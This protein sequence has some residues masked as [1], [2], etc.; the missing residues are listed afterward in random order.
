MKLFSAKPLTTVRFG[1][2]ALTGTTL[3]FLSGFLRLRALQQTDFAN[4]WDGYF[5]LVQLRAL[6]EEGQMH[7]PDNSLIYPLLRLFYSFNGDYVGSYQLLAATL[8]GSFTFAIFLVAFRW[9]GRATVA[10]LLGSISLFSPHLTYFTA[11]YPKNLLGL[12]LFLLLLA[13]WERRPR[14]LAWGLLL[15]NYFGHKL[16]FGLSVLWS[17]I[18]SI[19]K[20]I[21]W[22][23]LVGL[24]LGLLILTGLSVWFKAFPGWV[25]LERF[26]GMFQLSPN[27]APYAF[28]TTFGKPISL[29]WTGELIWT[30]ALFF[31]VIPFL[32]SASQKTIVWTLFLLSVLL[33]CPFLVWSY[34]GMAYRFFLVYV[35]ISPLFL[36]LLL[37]PRKYRISLLIIS[38]V[39]LILSPL[40]SY[41]YLPREHDAAYPQYAQVTERAWDILKDKEVELVIAH[42][43]LAEYFTFTTGID[44]LPWLPEYEIP[45]EKLWRIAKDLHLPEF[46]YYLSEDEMQQVVRLVGRYCIL[47]EYLWQKV[48]QK[49][50]A[51]GDDFLLEKVNT[52]RNP[53]RIRPAYLLRKKQ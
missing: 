53:H 46:G 40:A 23:W 22:Q 10:V 26:S 45:R 42:N 34:T 1:L 14:G 3:A 9:S 16:T 43:A 12:V 50:A 28:L 37:P 49:A 4:G 29:W 5:Y 15:V 13:V 35:L 30:S 52:W 19:N 6:V 25:D 41:S 20:K 18:W 21:P 32:R 36:S 38:V 27:W 44:A 33:L 8:A 39:F 47:P 31:L 11:Q 17:L 7:S 48:L 51:A 24:A 2:L